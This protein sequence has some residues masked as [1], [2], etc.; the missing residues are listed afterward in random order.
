VTALLRASLL[1]G[2]IIAGTL[3]F[4]LGSGQW[5]SPKQAQRELIDPAKVVVIRTSGGLL[6]VSTLIRNEE[7]GWST[8]HTCPMID[9][10]ALLTATITEIRV[11]VHYT[12][13]IPLSE[14]WTLKPDGDHYELTVPSADPKVPA[15]VDFTKMEMRTSKGWL[16]P[17]AKENRETLLRQLGPELARRSTQQHYIDAQREDARKTVAEF[18]GKWMQEQGAQKKLPV[19]VIFKDESKTGAP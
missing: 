19:K 5:F 17:S 10:G 9:C 11:P 14:T 1:I 16:S 2:V 18:A 12:Y 13:R 7:F 6:E 4:L 15:A 8:K 3:Y